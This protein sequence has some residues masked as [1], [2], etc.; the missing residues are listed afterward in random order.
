MEINLKIGFIGLGNMGAPMA[1]NLAKGGNEVFGFDEDNSINLREITMMSCIP[2]LLEE[3]DVVFTMLPSGL[4]VRDIIT[5]F[6]DNFKTNSILIDCS[7]IDV[8]TTKELSET[9]HK[10]NEIYMLD[11]PVS[12][13][14]HGAK[15]GELTFMVGGNRDVFEKVKFLF[16]YMGNRAVYCG[17]TGSGQSAKIC[18]NMILGVTM[19]ATCESFVL[20]DKLGLDREAMFEV[21]STSSGCSWSMNS[22]CP[23]PGIGPKAPSDNDYVP[24]FSS[25]LMLKDLLLSQDAACETQAN[26]P[27]GDLAMRLYKEFVES[28]NG[29]GLDFSAIIKTFE[30]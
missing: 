11:A 4:I 25:D 2:S 8:K 29:S 18:N 19:I 9:L 20:A 7:T 12:G 26:T 24:G 23:A 22:Y 3:V 14:V 21:V 27:M 17:K 10:N 6:I 16:T 30:K 15:S 28:S 13:G 5:K 1:I